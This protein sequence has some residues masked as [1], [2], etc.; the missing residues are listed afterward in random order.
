M[1]KIKSDASACPPQGFPVRITHE[2]VRFCRVLENHMK[3]VTI[4]FITILNESKEKHSFPR[5]HK[6]LPQ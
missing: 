1:A 3:T 4:T 5:L 6:G 2:R